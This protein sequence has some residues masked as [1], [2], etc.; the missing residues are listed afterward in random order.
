MVIK[1]NERGILFLG[2]QHSFFIAASL[3]RSVQRHI[4]GHLLPA[5]KPDVLGLSITGLPPV[6]ENELRQVKAA[7]NTRQTLVARHNISMG[8][9]VAFANTFK[10]NITTP[11]R[12]EFLPVSFRPVTPVNFTMKTYKVCM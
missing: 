7:P 10:Y 5:R 1:F 3:P 2:Y 9:I 12:S 4:I 6:T 8:T 11:Q